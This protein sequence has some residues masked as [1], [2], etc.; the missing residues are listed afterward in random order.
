MESCFNVTSKTCV[1][2]PFVTQPSL[3]KQRSRQL[4]L[5]KRPRGLCVQARISDSLPSYRL[6]LLRNSRCTTAGENDK[7]YSKAIADSPDDSRNS[8]YSRLSSNSATQDSPALSKSH[9]KKSV[10]SSFPPAY[11]L[12]NWID[13]RYSVRIAKQAE[14]YTAADIRCEAFY[15]APNDENYHPIR[16][17]EIY[18]AMQSRVN[19]GT[20]CV[21]LIDD[22]PPSSWRPLA[23]AEG[24]VV[25][26][27]DIT[28]HCSRTGKRKTSGNISANSIRT[29]VCAYISSMAVR[30]AWR[31]RGLAQRLMAHTTYLVR[32]LGVSDVFLHVDWENTAAVHIY[33]KCGFR[34]VCL[35]TSR[36][37]Q[38]LAKPEHT[39]MHLRLPHET[40]KTSS[41]L[42]D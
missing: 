15:C 4:E 1:S 26:T 7:Y 14:L 3:L 40:F 23:N 32:Q 19:S 6:A 36:W 28:L 12:S 9:Q 2:L 5:T 17:R 39:L 11:T 22:D 10:S 42:S 31:G 21:V 34:R 20:H 24:L 35:P 18:M 8:A 29:P 13:T 16:R 25:G 37:I 30:R 27:L 41:Q 38:T 33:A